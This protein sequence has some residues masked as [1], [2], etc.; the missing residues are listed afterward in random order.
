[1]IFAFCFLPSLLISGCGPGQFLGPTLAPR[2]TVTFTP[3][4]S[5][6]STPT[7]V[8]T[9]TPTLTPILTRTPTRAPT[10]VFPRISAEEEEKNIAN[11]IVIQASNEFEGIAKERQWLESNYPGSQKLAQAVSFNRGKVYDLIAILT[12]NGETKIIY[13][14][15][16]AFYG[17][18]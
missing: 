18:L 10:S 14:D 15:I 2:P 8:P 9:A 12:A 16:T 17:K 4:Q 7:I 6:T 3:T 13:F 5:P 11:A 1:M